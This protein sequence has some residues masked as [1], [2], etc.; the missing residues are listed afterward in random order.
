[1]WLSSGFCEIVQIRHLEHSSLYSWG[2]RDLK[3][4]SDVPKVAYLVS[5]GAG[6][7]PRSLTP[8]HKFLLS[9]LFCLSDASF[10]ICLKRGDEP[11]FC[12]LKPCSRAR[13]LEGPWPQDISSL[14]VSDVC[15][16]FSSLLCLSGRPVHFGLAYPFPLIGLYIFRWCW[17]LVTWAA[18]CLCQMPGH[19][20]APIIGQNLMLVCLS[21]SWAKPHCIPHVLTEHSA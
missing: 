11:G 9:V 15:L 5:G 13:T 17:S 12:D 4:L 3:K 6:L 8:E 2:R 20:C 18:S 14:D 1:M 21:P 7:K 10:F 19:A 16:S